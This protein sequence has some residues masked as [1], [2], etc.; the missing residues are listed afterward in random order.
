MWRGNCTSGFGSHLGTLM[1][2][3][4]IKR[5]TGEKLFCQPLSPK[6]S[7]GLN[8]QEWFHC[9]ISVMEKCNTTTGPLFQVS[10]AKGRSLKRASM[11]DI[12]PLF[13][14]LLKRVQQRFKDVIPEEVNVEAECAEEQRQ[15]LKM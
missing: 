10:G 13:H 4:R 3:G 6:S 15:K 8:I 11:T 5:E 14:Y 12:E 1:L 7:K 9:T 2:S